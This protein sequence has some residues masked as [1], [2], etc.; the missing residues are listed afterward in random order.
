ME[1][2]VARFEMLGFGMIVHFGLYSI[3]G[4]GAAEKIFAER[5]PNIMERYA[6]LEYIYDEITEFMKK[7]ASEANVPKALKNPHN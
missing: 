1:N 5:F 7:I 4:K 3:L 6:I 2:Y